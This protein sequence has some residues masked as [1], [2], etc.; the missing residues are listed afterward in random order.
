MQD[1]GVWDPWYKEINKEI[2]LG[3]LSLICSS[4]KSDKH[5][6][7]GS[8][9]PESHTKRRRFSKPHTAHTMQY[10]VCCKYWK[11]S[12]HN[13]IVHHLKGSYGTTWRWC[14]FPVMSGLQQVETDDFPLSG[15]AGRFFFW[16]VYQIFFSPRCRMPTQDEGLHRA[17]NSMQSAGLLSWN[18]NN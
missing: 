13:Y 4:Q 18:A 1:S 7:A 2:Y 9:A 11:G 14:L 17:E 16:P 8:A 10:T 12:R 6:S 15:S 5:Q 3:I